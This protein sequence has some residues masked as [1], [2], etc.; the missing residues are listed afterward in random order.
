MTDLAHTPPDSTQTWSG[1]ER[2]EDRPFAFDQ[3]KRAVIRSSRA[4]E[5][6][7]AFLRTAARQHADAERAYR[8]ALAEEIVRLKSERTA[9]TAA[10]D[11]ARGKPEIADLKFLRDLAEGI[12]EAAKQASFRHS[13]DRRALDQLIAWSMRV[14]LDGQG[15][16][17]EE[18]KRR[19]PI[20]ARS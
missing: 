12:Y 4:Q 1:P 16:E 14:S 3:A 9:V 17:S 19:A 15:R 10:G 6:G 2:N 20:G 7:E 13:A 11:I 8:K 18:D 5:E